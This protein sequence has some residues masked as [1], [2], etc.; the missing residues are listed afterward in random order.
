MRPFGKPSIRHKL[1]LASLL[2]CAAVL[3][4]GFSAFATFEAVQ[5]RRALAAEITAIGAVI[6]HN[7]TAALLF[8]DQEDARTTLSALRSTSY[9]RRAELLTPDG[10]AF[11]SVGFGDD[12][13]PARGNTCASQA[14]SPAES[15]YVTFRDRNSGLLNFCRVLVVDGLTVGTLHLVADMRQVRDEVGSFVIAGAATTLVLLILAVPLSWM[16][17]HMVSAPITKL[18]HVMTRVARDK[19]YAIRID[20]HGDDEVGTL[21]ERFND[22]LAQIGA[23]EASIT[24]ARLE[25]E[26]SN[27]AISAFLA[28]TSHELRTPLNAIIGFSEMIKSQVMGVASPT[29]VGYATDIW[30]SGNHLLQVINGLLDLS[31]IEAGKFELATEPIDVGQLLE[32][33]LR[34]AGD[35]AKSSEREIE[36]RIS[37]DPMTLHADDRLIRQSLLNL[38]SNAIKFT[39]AGGRIVLRAAADEDGSLLLSVSDNGI[40][41]KSTDLATILLPFGRAEN[42]YNRKHEGTGLGLPLVK[43]FTELHGGRLEIDSEPGVGTTVTM[44]LPAYR[45][46]IGPGAGHRDQAGRDDDSAAEAAQGGSPTGVAAAAIS[47]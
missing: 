34:L 10:E 13:A 39:P 17:Q 19:N 26:A 23:H 22:M 11:V 1:V 21:I 43:K 2:T 3:A 31:K 44:R 14:L 40:G 16:L 47:A 9:I 29:Y 15:P 36:V 32:R 33:T 30:H 42:A 4:V 7:S 6:G 18:A 41:I 35:I 12:G 25:A 8:Q 37:T 45:L 46:K 5:Q 20:E 28:N 27:R 24:A 38:L